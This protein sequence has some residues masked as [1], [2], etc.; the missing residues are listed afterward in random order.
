VEMCLADPA[1]TAKLCRR[2]KFWE[3]QREKYH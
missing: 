1:D 2:G 3:A